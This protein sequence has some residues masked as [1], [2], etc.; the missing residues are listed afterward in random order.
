MDTLH[1]LGNFLWDCKS[2]KWGYDQLSGQPV[3]SKVLAKQAQS[4]V[5][6]QVCFVKELPG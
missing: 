4:M 1:C 3:L 6:K 5:I 2:P